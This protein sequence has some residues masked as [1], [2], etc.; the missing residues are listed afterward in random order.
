[1]ATE[2][3]RVCGYEWLSSINPAPLA[4]TCRG[5]RR[6]L[7]ANVISSIVLDVLCTKA[8]LLEPLAADERIAL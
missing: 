3:E 1:M 7:I 4:K 5:D 6:W 8:H 2:H